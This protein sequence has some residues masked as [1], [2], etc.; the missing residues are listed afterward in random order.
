VDER[1]ELVRE[2]PSEV[3]VHVRCDEECGA[4]IDPETID[5]LRAA[6]EHWIAHSVLHGCSHGC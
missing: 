4:L 5:E 6:L 1:N 2:I 3:N